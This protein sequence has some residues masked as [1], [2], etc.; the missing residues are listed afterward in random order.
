MIEISQKDFESR[1]QDVIDGKTTRTQLIE[2]LKTDR[3]TLN[4]KIQELV[5]YNPELYKKF[6]EKFPY[7]PREYTH[8]DYEA[9]IIDIL[10]NGYTR[11]ELE[12]VYGISSR[13]IQRKIHLIE[14]NNP[15]LVQLYR[16]V[17]RY[18]KQQKELPKE[19][20]EKV[21][22]L[23][24]SEI[25]VEGI[26][27][28]KREELLEE[29]RRYNTKLMEGV[30]VTQASRELGKGRIS[31]RIDTLNRIQIEMMSRGEMPAEE[32]VGT[33]INRKRIRDY[34]YK[35]DS[36]E[37]TLTQAAEELGISRDYLKKLIT[38]QIGSDDRKREEFL[39]RLHQNKTQNASIEI[40]DTIMDNIRLFISGKITIQEASRI[41]NIHEETFS[42]KVY[43]ALSQNP[44]LL[45]IYLR[46]GANKRDYSQVNTRLV[47][48]NML[49]NNMNQSEM[50]R[51]LGI[52][53]RTISGW[54]NKLPEDDELRVW[55]KLSADRALQ[56]GKLSEI[57]MAEL[58]KKLDRYVEEHNIHEEP[59]DT[60][61]IEERE[62]AKTQEFLDKV[63]RL[64][65]EKDENGKKKYTR[66]QIMDMLGVGYSAIRRAEIK[67]DNLILIIENR[68]NKGIEGE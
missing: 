26:Y 3:N 47:I 40:N 35:I 27:D 51:E 48:I 55:A 58:I 29:E 23:V 16:E 53:T 9:L 32:K 57:E 28:Q 10:K 18:R 68:K 34:Y 12:G 65:E 36:G 8:I 31:K 60:R 25:F 30:S 11:R 4:N 7:K 63:Y 24:E 6:I 46:N 62:L 67:R 21:D 56:G 49:R 50:S 19:L 17:S 44:A 38:E 33:Q 20:Q 14:A 66:K 37:L 41:C 64:E 61:S 59:L 5:V 52:P 54:V 39:A 13:T 15:E 45:E 42:R 43:E 2:E 1:I 22:Q